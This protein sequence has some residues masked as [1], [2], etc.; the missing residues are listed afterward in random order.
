M[1]ILTGGGDA[2][3]LN[4]VLRAFVRTCAGLGI[5][6]W[7]SEDGFEGLI[8]PHRLVRLDRKAVRGILPKGGSILGC[9]NRANP[10]AYPVKDAR[11]RE[12]Y[13]DVSATVLKRLRDH[14]IDAVV[15]VGGDGT[16]HHA[17]SLAKRGV[18]VIGVPKTID[19]DLAATDVTF[20]FDTALNTAT[21]AIDALHATAE[22]H[23]R[24]M[25]VELMGREAGWIALCAGIAGGADVIL[26]PEIPYDI[27]R[28]IRKIHNRATLGAS[29]SIIVIGEGARPRHGRPSTIARA[30]KGHLARLGGAGAALAHELQGHIGHEIRVTVLGHIQR[31]GS[32]SAFDRVLG[33]RFGVEAARMCA[34]GDKGRMVALRGAELITVPLA[35]AIGAAKLVRPKSELV[36]AAR[37]IGIELGA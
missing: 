20:G 18:S 37:R 32:P 12:R 13:V 17:L 7:G 29:F 27:R 3:G 10:W 14:D 35:R 1:A 19:N 34:R 30:R 23:D 26:I 5:E 21:W 6:V 25:I 31:G 22:S 9:S 36:D 15:L 11:G 2:P 8:Q 16:M 33:T 4:A 28:V 24:V